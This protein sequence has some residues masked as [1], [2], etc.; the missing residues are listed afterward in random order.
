MKLCQKCNQEILRTGI[1]YASGIV[2]DSECEFWA[3]AELNRVY[4][5]PAIAKKEMFEK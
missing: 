2:P 5:H 1:P 3:H 4:I